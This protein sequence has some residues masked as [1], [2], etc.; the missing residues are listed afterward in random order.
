MGGPV[1]KYAM[2]A[3]VHATVNLLQLGTIARTA[4]MLGQYGVEPAPLATED[5]LTD[6][7]KIKKQ[8]LYE[9]ETVL[10]N[11]QSVCL[12]LANAAAA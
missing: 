6:Y 12:Q 10:V 8:T 2:G 7:L 3:Y 1:N 9:Q 11:D 4:R 5:T